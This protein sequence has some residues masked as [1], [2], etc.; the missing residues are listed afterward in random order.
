MV[1]CVISSFC[2][3]S[4]TGRKRGKV[5]WFVRVIDRETGEVEF[6]N[7]EGQE[8]LEDALFKALEGVLDDRTG[9]KGTS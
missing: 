2:W 5:C 1:L 9:S 4:F 8:E 6:A 7:M 3:I